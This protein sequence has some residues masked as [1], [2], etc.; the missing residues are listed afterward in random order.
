[1]YIFNKS[2][3]IQAGSVAGETERL[4]MKFGNSR[5][6]SQRLMGR[7]RAVTGL[8]RERAVTSLHERDD[9]NRSDDWLQSELAVVWSHHSTMAGNIPSAGIGDKEQT[10]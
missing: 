8:I 2:M 10:C 9:A 6:T 4:I 3:R 7:V 5:P 1:M